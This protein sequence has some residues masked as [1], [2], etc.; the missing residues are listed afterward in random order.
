MDVAHDPYS[1]SYF[2]SLGTDLRIGDLRPLSVRAT[3]GHGNVYDI[4]TNGRE[5]RSIRLS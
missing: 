3:L 2:L 1:E 4:E 5:E